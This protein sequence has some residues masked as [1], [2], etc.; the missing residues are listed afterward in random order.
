MA[1]LPVTLDAVP[2]SP[3]IS[4]ELDVVHQAITKQ[5]DIN[6]FLLAVAGIKPEDLQ[7]VV[8]QLRAALQAEETKFFAHEG[9]VRE[10]RNVINWK[11][12]LEA[13]EKWLKVFKLIG[14]ADRKLPSGQDV[15]RV[16]VDLAP[17]LKRRPSA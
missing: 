7:N 10:S 4:P 3:E 1:G 8:A 9:E 17:D 15:L 6:K 11:A 14:G 5:E 12:R 2:V 13:I 16:E